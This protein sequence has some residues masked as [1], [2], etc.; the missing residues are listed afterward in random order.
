MTGEY[1]LERDGGTGGVYKP[2]DKLPTVEN[3]MS[4]SEAYKREYSLIEVKGKGW[5]LKAGEKFSLT[6]M[7][8][9]PNIVRNIHTHPIRDITPKKSWIPSIGDYK[10]LEDNARLG[11]TDIMEI[12]AR[13]TETGR[14]IMKSFSLSQLQ[15][16]PYYR[17]H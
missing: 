5:F 11:G 17:N 10:W 8:P 2:I 1:N 16:A 15:K 14:A 3:L 9:G 13:C 4:L 12:I 6:P 7:R